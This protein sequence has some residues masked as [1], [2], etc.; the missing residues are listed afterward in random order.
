MKKFLLI[1]ALSIVLMASVAAVTVR[2]GSFDNPPKMY[3]EDGE[4]KGFWADITNYIAEQEGW[5]IEWVYGTWEEHRDNLDS[6]AIDLMP[7]VSYSTERAENWDFNEETV[8][9]D[10]SDVYT[11]PSAGIDSFLDLEGKRVAVMEGS[12]NYVGPKG[13]KAMLESFEINAEYVE[14]TDYEEA[15][16]AAQR[17]EA[18]AAVSNHL[19]GESHDTQYGLDETG[20]MFSATKTMYAM[21]KGG[22]LNILLAEGIDRQVIEMKNDPN[23]VYY[24]ALKAQLGDSHLLEVMPAWAIWVIA[25]LAL[26]VVVGIWGVFVMRE[27]QQMYKTLIDRSPIPSAVFD[28]NGNFVSINRSFIQSTGFLPADL[29][30][31]HFREV[32]AKEYLN[33][34]EAA[35]KRIVGGGASSTVETGIKTKSG[36]QKTYEV[37][38]ELIRKGG[39]SRIVAVFLDT[40]EKKRMWERLNE[41]ERKGGKKK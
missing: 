22:S 21:P 14:Y 9:T 11:S 27:G 40:T 24:K 13:I 2:V 8:L 37:R 35:F 25:A 28:K 26:L 20:M 39:K 33:N 36:M 23:S 5:E 15:F 12:I 30:G 7:D 3:V 10:W 17:G 41:I 31:R 32:I 16:A 19:F 6:G 4:V 29:I 34:S 18:D 38:S 1:L